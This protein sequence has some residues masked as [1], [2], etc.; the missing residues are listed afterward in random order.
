MNAS[1]FGCFDV[2][3]KMPSE[4]CSTSKFLV[5]SVIEHRT[6]NARVRGL[7]P[8]RGAKI[9]PLLMVAANRFGYNIFEVNI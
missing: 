8:R 4:P 6:V 3:Q 9:V 2:K 5:S 1:R 7:N